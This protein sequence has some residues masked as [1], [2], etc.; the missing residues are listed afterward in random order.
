[1]ERK[2][3]SEIHGIMFTGK[4]NIPWEQVEGYLKTYIGKEYVVEEYQDTI[5]I[6]GDF[7]DEY[8]ESV[9][10]K[11]LRGALAKVKANAA[12]IIGELIIHATNRR[13]VVNKAEKHRHHAEE[14]WFRYDTYFSMSVQGSGEKKAR[15][16]RFAATLIVRKTTKGMFLY[17]MINIKKE[18]STPLESQR[19]YG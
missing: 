16:N 7:P 3:Y 2:I 18:A 17:D 13:W 14:G 12:Q 11:K 15:V 6:A 1:M 19:P 5:R 9:Y 4:Q 10:T 8:T